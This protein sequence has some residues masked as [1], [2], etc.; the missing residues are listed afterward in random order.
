MLAL[1][2]MSTAVFAQ[3]TNGWDDLGTLLEQLVE[4]EQVS[5]GNSDIP[6]EEVALPDAD[7]A[8]AAEQHAA[9]E[10]L[11]DAMDDKFSYAGPEK[12]EVSEVGSDFVVVSTTQVLYDGQPVSKYKIY[13]SDTTLSNFQDFEKIQDKEVD[14]EKTEGTMV[15]L[16]LDELEANKTYYVVVSPVHPTDPQAEPLTMISAEVTFMTKDMAVS[17]TTKVFENVSYTYDNNMV[18][19]TWTPSN[20][21]DAAEIHI[22][23]QS[24]GVYTKVGTPKMAEGK[25]TF[26]VNKSGNYFLKL[27]GTDASGKQMGQEHIQTVKVEEVQQQAEPVQAAPKVGPTTDLLMILLVL[28]VVFYLV[29]RFRKIE[30]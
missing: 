14:I 1:F 27:I 7:T 19:V 17:P 4:S 29:F 20:A 26:S 11:L 9:A 22:R 6:E 2:G 25:F 28:G 13:Y 18:T 21:V 8:V 5:G 24:E 30:N 15:F 10:D 12:I 3:W 16:K 23:H